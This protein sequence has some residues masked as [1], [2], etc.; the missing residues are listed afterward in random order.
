MKTYA[1]L[2]VKH[3]REGENVRGDLV[4][5]RVILPIVGIEAP[6]VDGRERAAG[7]DLQASVSVSV[8]GN[9]ECTLA[10]G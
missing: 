9:L 5:P 3:D 7:A 10:G 2:K 1:R 8:D 6:S 4:F